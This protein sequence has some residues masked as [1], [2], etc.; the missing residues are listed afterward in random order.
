VALNYKKMF[1]IS[2]NDQCDAEIGCQGA[3]SSSSWTS[4]YGGI[5]AL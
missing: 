2:P 5:K 3:C 1:A 4:T